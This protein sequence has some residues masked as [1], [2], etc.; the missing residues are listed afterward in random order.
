MFGKKQ[1]NKE[2]IRFYNIH[3]GVALVH[4]V[5]KAS[6]LNRPW[7]KDE[8]EVHNETKSKCPLKRFNSS[9]TGFSKNNTPE[10]LNDFFG[11]MRNELPDIQ[12][13]L[14]NQELYPH[15]LANCPGLNALM[16]N[17]FIIK[18]PVD[19]NVFTIDSNI[20]GTHHAEIAKP[21][22]QIHEF[23]HT[24]WLKDS[25]KDI[26]ANQIL[27]INTGWRVICDPDIIFL[28]VKTPYIREDRFSAV[29]GILD[30]HI[31]PEI[32]LQLWWH[33]DNGDVNIK[34]GTPLAMYLP[35]SRK[36]LTYDASIGEASDDE[37]R[38]EE[39]YKYICNKHF[40][41]NRK[42]GVGVNKIVNHYWNLWKSKS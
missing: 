8:K 1:K 29:Y 32:N 15:A 37:L 41:E 40:P 38:M 16:G 3:P 9:L 23:H 39:A 6:D 18:S 28:Q 11:P 30:P 35:I 19:F 34:A 26:T 10:S 4:P 7:I 36:Y 21:F 27:K 2:Q 42:I 17:G 33:I 22:V 13:E 5:I 24:G 31:S 14:L 12:K 20:E 25:N